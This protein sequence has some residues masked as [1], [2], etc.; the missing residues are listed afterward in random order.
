MA[1]ATVPVSLVVPTIGRMP[2]LAQLL[3]SVERCDPLPAETLI[4]DQGTDPGVAGL[5]DRFPTLG[6]HH[7]PS[8]GRH[9]GL[10]R[11]DGWHA[12][13]NEVV[14]G[15]D[16]DCIVAPDWVGVAWEHMRRH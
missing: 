2:L 9:P 4:V 12:A 13:S 3:E 8:A 14:V 7:V 6:V 11:N 15:T 1:T 10:A 5:A 16:D